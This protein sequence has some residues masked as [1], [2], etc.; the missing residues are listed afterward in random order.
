MVFVVK[1]VIQI[2]IKIR[3]KTWLLHFYYNK[4]MVH[5]IRTVLVTDAECAVDLALV[6]IT[7]SHGKLC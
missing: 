3:Q 7:V 2:I 1:L 6:V 4:T 5:F